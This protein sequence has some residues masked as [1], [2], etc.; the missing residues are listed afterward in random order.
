V[1]IT[2]NLT[3]SWSIIE[4]GPG[5][6]LGVRI[7][8]IYWL[9]NSSVLKYHGRHNNRTVILFAEFGTKTKI[10]WTHENATIF[11]CICVIKHSFSYLFFQILFLNLDSHIFSPK[12]NL[13]LSLSVDSLYAVSLWVSHIVHILSALIMYR[14]RYFWTCYQC[15]VLCENQISLIQV[16]L[17]FYN[18][19]YT[20]VKDLNTALSMPLLLLNPEKIFNLWHNYSYMGSRYSDWLRAGPQRGRVSS[21]G[22][23]N[24]FLFSTSSNPAL[25]LTQPSIYWVPG[26]LFPGGRGVKQQEREADHSTPTNA[27]IKKLWICISTP[28]YAFMA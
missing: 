1:T 3:S 22:K 17:S 12:I 27:E 6:N 10:E 25:W 19:K 13:T 4:F 24:N 28:P 23:V 16:S 15:V 20:L 2:Q 26:A 14:L 8:N 9:N 5:L 18:L 11:V 7:W 21:P